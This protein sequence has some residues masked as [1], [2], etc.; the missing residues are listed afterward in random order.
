LSAVDL[1][2]TRLWSVHIA[3][4]L[5][6]LFL[7]AI[8]GALHLDGVGDT[9]DGL[10]S[11]RGKNRA[12]EIMKDSRIGV[13]ALVSVVFLLA[14]KWGGVSGLQHHRGLILILVPAYA[15]AAVLFGIRFLPYG[16]KAGTGRSFFDDP[17]DNRDFL[18]FAVPVVLS[19]WLGWTGLALNMAFALIVLLILQ[20]YRRQMGC[21]TG[22]MLG[23]MIEVT[24]M[25][26]FI[27][28]S[29]RYI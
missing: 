5:D 26:L 13:M 20:F 15:R 7:A 12:L 9:A 19:V 23:A 11:H 10:F 29:I 2:A 17:L 8:T 3:S 4:L 16:R 1:L 22:D 27:V 28:I 18:P 24:E 6:V 21:I 14:L 25:F